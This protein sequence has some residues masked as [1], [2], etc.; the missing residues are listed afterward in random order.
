[1]VPGMAMSA[2]EIGL[3]TCDVLT[4]A[5]VA[6]PEAG[7]SG[8]DQTT[9]VPEMKLLPFTVSVKPG[10]PAVTLEIDSEEIEGVGPMDIGPPNDA[11]PPPPQ[12]G[13]PTR[14]PSTSKQSR[15]RE[16]ICPSLAHE[17]TGFCGGLF[18]VL[19]QCSLCLYWG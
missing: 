18:D 4:N 14:S 11:P 10:S 2:A 7:L 16:L 3:V 13:N 15:L 1:T 6:V 8:L 12:A 17:T 9:V 5:V 19:T